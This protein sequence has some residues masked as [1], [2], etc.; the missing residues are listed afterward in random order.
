MHTNYKILIVKIIK[1]APTWF[2]SHKT[3]IRD[4]HPVL[5]VTV[6]QVFRENVW[7]SDIEW[8]VV[9]HSREKK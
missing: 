4:P 7:A 8:P 2:G 1:S 5:R 3:I 6:A 9:R